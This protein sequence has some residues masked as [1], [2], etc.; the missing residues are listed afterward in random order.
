MDV[1][2]KATSLRKIDLDN[3][4]LKEISNEDFFE[5]SQIF[6]CSQLTAPFSFINFFKTNRFMLDSY[7]PTFL[8]RIK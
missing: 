6:V 5:P 4:N 2:S 8:F 7:S 3:N 1:L